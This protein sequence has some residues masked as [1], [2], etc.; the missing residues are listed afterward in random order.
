[1]VSKGNNEYLEREEYEYIVSLKKRRS[2]EIKATLESS[3]S[4]YERL[5]ENLFTKEVRLEDVRYLIYYNPEKA[6]DDLSF[7]EN[8]IQRQKKSEKLAEMMKKGRLIGLKKA[9][10]FPGPGDSQFG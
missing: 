5:E 2:Q 4:K 3:P 10:P 7:R 6:K 9:H 1:M 8:L